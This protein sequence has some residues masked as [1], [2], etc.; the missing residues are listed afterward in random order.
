MIETY[1]IFN[2]WFIFY[3]DNFWW[4]YPLSSGAISSIFLV[5][6]KYFLDEKVKFKNIVWIIILSYI[7]VVSITGV[8]IISV[9]LLFVNIIL[10]V[11]FLI[12]EIKKSKWWN[13]ELL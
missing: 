2:E 12:D 5:I 13:K 3:M 8:I 4:T 10:I 1:N 7:P 6:W 11:G 9:F